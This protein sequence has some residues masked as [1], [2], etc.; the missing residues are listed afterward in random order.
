MAPAG[1][2]FVTSDLSQIEL[3]IAACLA[4]E[5]II[6]DALRRKDCVYSQFASGLFGVPV[7]KALAKV[8]EKVAEHRQIGKVSVLQCQYASGA[9][10]LRKAL[11]VQT[12]GKLVMTP[13][14]ARQT[15]RTYRR[16]Y[17]KFP[18]FWR[19][20]DK[21]IECWFFTDPKLAAARA[22]ASS[23]Y[24]DNY[25]RGLGSN[26]FDLLQKPFLNVDYGRITGPHGLALKYPDIQYDK[27]TTSYTYASFAKTATEG[28]VGIYGGK[29][30]ENLC[31]WLARVVMTDAMLELRNYY[32]IVM[33]VHDELVL[34]VP[35]AL[36]EQAKRHV[37]HVMSQS[38][39][40]WPE[41]PVECEVGVGQRYGDAK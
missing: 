10:A 38:P 35:D 17:Q 24:A 18:E 27:D 25:V 36:V 8:D 39:S 2:K 33:T 5:T 12:E 32:K 34:L 15:V 19:L 11:W 26:S 20:L 9:G 28:R 21:Q 7:S 22:A 31:Q 40:W 37:S 23:T 6:L 4:G 14:E 16:T 30:F 41:L 13:D 29:L 1:W 3:R